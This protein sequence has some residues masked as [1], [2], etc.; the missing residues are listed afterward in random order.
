MA[1]QVDFAFSSFYVLFCEF[2]GI[3]VLNVSLT[4][5]SQSFQFK[6]C[7]CQLVYS[8]LVSQLLKC[9]TAVS[10]M[11][12]LMSHT[13]PTKLKITPATVHEHA[14]LAFLN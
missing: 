9:T 8:I 5:E 3:L 11:P 6:G 7:F 4:K 13:Q 1:K 2:Y 14:T 12:W 10:T